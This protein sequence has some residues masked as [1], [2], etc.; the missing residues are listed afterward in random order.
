VDV[1]QKATEWQPQ[2]L[3]AE[4]KARGITLR[5]LAIEAGE[6]HS[7]LSEALAGGRV[8]PTRRARI[9]AAAR[10]LLGEA[11]TGEDS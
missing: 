2:E 8:G 6:Y 5:R 11:D 1:E 3:R 7:N 9:E 10:R 4:L